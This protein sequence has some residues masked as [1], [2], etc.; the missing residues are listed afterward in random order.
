MPRRRRPVRSNAG[1]GLNRRHLLGLLGAGVGLPKVAPAKRRRPGDKPNLLF[2]QTDQHRYDTMAA[3]GNHRFRVPAMNRL[4]SESVVFDQCYVSQPICTPSRATLM[5]G[6]WP[7]QHGCIDNNMPL[8]ASVPTL[9]ERLNGSDYRTGFFGKWHL[10]D[11]LFPQRG[12]QEWVSVED[13]YNEH[14]SPGRDRARRSD[15]HHFLVRAGYEPDDGDRFSRL[16]ATQLPLELCKPAFLA[17][18]AADF[19]LRHRSAPWMLH[20]S[21]L[22]PHR[23]YEGPLNDLH[24]AEEAP[25]PANFPGLPMEREPRSYERSRESSRSKGYDIADPAVIQRLSRNYAGLCAQVDMAI[26][27]VLW[28]LEASGQA[29]N[30]VIVLTADHGEMMGSHTL[31]AK[32]VMYE[33]SIR[34][35]LLLRVPFEQSGGMHVGPPVSNV[36]VVPTLLE[37][38]GLPDPNGLPGE[39][40]FGL[41]RGEPPRDSHVPVEWFGP[42][43][44][45]DGRAV[46]APD[47]W[48]LVVYDGDTNMLFNRR[49]DPLEMDNLYY[50][51][52]SQSVIRRLRGE[53]DQWQRDVGD[54]FHARGA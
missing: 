22:E 26:A 43:D 25:I 15:Y 38:L 7:H 37:A 20:V 54:P 14:F 29:D 16:F 6:L 10:G 53:L 21:F 24:S 23:P 12:Y 51:E 47:G 35:P 11:E 8:P 42:S 4:A 46:I 5:S 27:E 3:Y 52:S 39:S 49:R 40:L 2:L 34:V 31:L 17:S 1:L 32:F 45:I 36:S 30:T 33:E 19:I 9:P 50:R 41:C 18:K 48:K 44:G 13:G 28:A